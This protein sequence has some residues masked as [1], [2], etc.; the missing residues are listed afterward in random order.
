MIIKPPYNIS[1]KEEGRYSVFLAGSIEMGKAENWQ[2]SLGKFLEEKGYIIF[3]PRRDDWDS[4]WIQ[5]YENPQFFQQV[6]WELNA[7][8]VSDLIIMN[9]IPD[10]ISPI[11]LLELGLFA[12]SKKIKVICPEGYFRKGN[13]EVICAEYGIPLYNSIEQFKLSQYGRH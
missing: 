4:A 10:T 5:T 13:V 7:L 6:H 12:T 9:F 11:S 2:D 3:N 8:R 1:K